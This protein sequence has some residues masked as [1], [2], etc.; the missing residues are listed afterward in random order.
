MYLISI[1]TVDVVFGVL[2]R[3]ILKLASF[4]KNTFLKIDLHSYFVGLNNIN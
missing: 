1:L 2:S 4:R 3:A